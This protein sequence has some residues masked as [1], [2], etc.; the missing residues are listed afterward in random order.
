MKIDRTVLRNPIGVFK[1]PM[2]E[3]LVSQGLSYKFFEDGNYN[4]IYN[5]WVKDNILYLEKNQELIITNKEGEDSIVL[6]RVEKTLPPSSGIG[7]VYV[8]AV[9]LRIGISTEEIR[10]PP[11]VKDFPLYPPNWGSSTSSIASLPPAKR[12]ETFISRFRKVAEIEEKRYG[13]PWEV[14]LAQAGLESSWGS[15]R[16]AKEANNFFGHKCPKRKEHYKKRPNGM[17]QGHYEGHCYHFKD[18]GPSDMFLINRNA[19]ESFRK[20]S[21]LLNKDRYKS[22]LKA[23]KCEKHKIRF[24]L[25]TCYVETIHKAGYATDPQYSEKLMRIIKSLK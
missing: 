22:A 24:E 23:A 6:K 18:D 17:K 8:G 7:P 19:W 25:V 13:V 20:H 4:P 21:H 15:S 9:I 1:S 14:K 12:K 10:Y 3:L 2:E 5:I 16:L 11:R